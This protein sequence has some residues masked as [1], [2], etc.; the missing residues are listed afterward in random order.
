VE[1]E[2]QVVVFYPTKGRVDSTGQLHFRNLRLDILVHGE[3][4]D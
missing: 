1:G 2:G 3:S 4:L